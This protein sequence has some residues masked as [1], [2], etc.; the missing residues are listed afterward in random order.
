MFEGINTSGSALNA[1]KQWMELSS[2]N[3]ANADSSAEPGETPFLRKRV[4]LS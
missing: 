3:I 2:N 1:A 4:V